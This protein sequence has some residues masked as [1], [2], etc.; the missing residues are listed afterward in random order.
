MYARGVVGDV[1]EEEVKAERH[2][3]LGHSEWHVTHLIHHH[4]DVAALAF[5]GSQFEFLVTV[6]CPKPS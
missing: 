5:I 4:H 2:S 3:W 1:R 6:Y